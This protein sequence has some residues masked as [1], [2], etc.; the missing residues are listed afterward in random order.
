M[1]HKLEEREIEEKRA[2]L[3]RKSMLNSESSTSMPLP[4]RHPIMHDL[5][6]TI[7]SNFPTRLNCS[8]TSPSPTFYGPSN[9]IAGV[10]PYG[11]NLGYCTPMSSEL[12]SSEV[13]EGD[14]NMVPIAT[15]RASAVG[16]RTNL[17]HYFK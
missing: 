3:L 13:I 8:L 4:D 15:S 16:P 17:P 10:P 14:E 11:A 6:N 9:Y 1:E 5:L 2:I 12:I 7:L